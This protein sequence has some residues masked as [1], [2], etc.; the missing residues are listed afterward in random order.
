MPNQISKLDANMRAPEFS[1]AT[2]EDITWHNPSEKP[3]RI[4][5]FPWFDQEQIYR[6]LPLDKKNQLPFAVDQ[7]ANCTAGGA[8]QFKTDSSQIMLE[9]ELTEH[10]GRMYHMAATGESGFDLYCGEPGNM[11]YLKTTIFEV[12]CQSYTSILLESKE[13]PR[14][15]EFKIH[16][17]LYNGV[18]NVKIGL[19]KD[20]VISSPTAYSGKKIVVYGGS[21][22]QGAC[23]SRPGRCTLNI[24][25]E[26]LNREVVNLGFSGSG[27]MEPALAEVI[28]DIPDMA[29]LMIEAERNTGY[30]GMSEKLIPFLRLVRERHPILPISIWSAN[31]RGAEHFDVNQRNERLQFLKLFHNTLE[32]LNDPHLYLFDS[33]ELLGKD[34]WECSVDGVHPNDLGFSRMA[35]GIIPFIQTIL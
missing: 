19:T 22:A 21:T 11:K 25:A 15:R 31:P 28:A 12:G 9:V 23:A 3:F 32:S 5:G 2:V 13:I 18:K 14:L 24:M 33:S 30:A 8:V 10:A 27:K 29:L 17:P 20:A 34:F 4:A 16:F 1:D 6:R 26:K 7:L 35:D